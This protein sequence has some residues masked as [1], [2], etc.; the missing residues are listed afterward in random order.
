MT[1]LNTEHFKPLSPETDARPREDFR[2]SVVPNA[3]EVR[4][5]LSPA[6]SARDTMEPGAPGTRNCEPRVTLQRDGDR[7]THIHVQ[8]A[9]GQT[10]ELAC[11][12]DE[13]QPLP[14][15]S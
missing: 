15:A 9:C 7:I 8:C 6:D 1:L 12:Y 10:L 13:P 14:K 4:S 5:F 2:L 11:V 3:N